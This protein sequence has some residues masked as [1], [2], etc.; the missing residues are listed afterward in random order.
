LTAAG[1]GSVTWQGVALNEAEERWLYSMT[2]H[3]THP[4]PVRIGEAIARKHFPEPVRSFLETAGCGM[5]GSV[6][7]HEIWM[8]S[9]AWIASR[10]VQAS[11][12]PQSLG[13]TVLVAIDGK[14]RGAFVL[15]SAL[16]PA[17]DALISKLSS[18]YDLAL[19]SGDNE[20]ES[21]KFT[22]LF[23]AAA[24]LEFNQSP[25]NKLGFIRNLQQSG[26]TTMMV[27]D[28]LNDAG[29][30][31]QSDVGVAVAENVTAFAPASDIIMAAGRVPQLANVLR[32]SKQSV[33]VVRGAFLISTVYNVVGVAIAASGHLSPVVCAILMPVSSVTVVAFACGVTTW[34]GRGLGREEALP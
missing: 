22:A 4:L 7:G 32:Y 21:A 31:K 5:E 24:H 6:A 34:L 28:G 2:R 29:A 20:R 27:G 11:L 1:A 23:G 9:A 30:L 19:L 12:Q 25:L 17:A 8:G 10:N 14:Y 33:R 13:S 18:G 16:R 26:K 3:S 15:A